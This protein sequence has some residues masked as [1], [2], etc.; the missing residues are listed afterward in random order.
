[1]FSLLQDFVNTFDLATGID[2]LAG[3][4][5]LLLWFADQKL[6]NQPTLS[7]N[8]VKR[9]QD[10][11]E[12]IREL[13]LSHGGMPVDP[14]A[15]MIIRDVWE[16][17]RLAPLIDPEGYPRLIPGS[18]G[19]AAGL[20]MLAASL[21]L[22]MHSES[23]SRL[24]VCGNAQCQR[25]F[26]DRSKNRSGKWCSMTSCGNRMKVRAYRRRKRLEMAPRSMANSGD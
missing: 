24:K 20:G 14:A 17:G 8:A 5:G 16:E 3:P 18:E 25:I 13:I 1:V 21:F 19:I 2:Q 7:N 23:W 12:S 10:L 15:A 4:E 22:A 26:Y 6:V 9:A 11:R